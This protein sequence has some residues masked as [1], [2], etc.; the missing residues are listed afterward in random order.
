M[1]LTLE[2]GKLEVARNRLMTDSRV[3][4]PILLRPSA[5]KRIP[6]VL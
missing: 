6:F 5:E 3:T 1:R 4:G 2:L